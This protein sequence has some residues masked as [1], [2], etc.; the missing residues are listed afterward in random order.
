MSN[1]DNRIS[2]NSVWWS[3]PTHTDP[4]QALRLALTAIDAGEPIPKPAARVLAGALRQYLSGEQTDIT[5]ALGLRPRRGGA[6]EAPIRKERRRARDELINRAFHALKGKDG[7]R[8]ECVAQMLAEPP[9][10]SVITEADLF[11]CI[12]ELHAQ[13]G[14]DLPS[15]GRQILRVVRGETTTG[16]HQKN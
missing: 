3:Q 1:A 13:H 9:V 4:L 8:A 10:S 7:H 12:E 6:S 16:R 2:L 15:S 5:R 14:G 11:A